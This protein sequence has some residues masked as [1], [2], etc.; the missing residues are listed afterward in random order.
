[1]TLTP[2][3]RMRNPPHTG[4]VVLDRCFEES[5]T[6]PQ[7]TER[8]GVDLAELQPVLDGEAPMTP[9]LAIALEE[10][11]ISNASL[12]MRMRGSDR[13]AQERLRREREG[14]GEPA[15]LAAAPQQAASAFTS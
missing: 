8:I 13:L 12:W 6:T 7:M 1:M 2:P 9:S 14:V 10:A 3:K 5:T 15:I 11:G 4:Q